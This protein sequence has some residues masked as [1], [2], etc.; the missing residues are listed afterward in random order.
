MIKIIKY[1]TREVTECKTCGCK[2][3]YEK[4]DLRNEDTDNY[5]AF[6]E[7]VICPQCEQEVIIRAVR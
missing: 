7:Y 2:F 6:K 1:G 3:S 5:K 4:E